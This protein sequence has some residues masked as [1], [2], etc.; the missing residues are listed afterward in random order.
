MP[1]H[2]TRLSFVAVRNLV[3]DGDAHDWYPD[4]ISSLFQTSYDILL[5][6]MYHASLLGIA[7]KFGPLK[8]AREGCHK[9]VCG[10]QAQKQLGIRNIF[11]TRRTQN[12]YYCINQ[13]L[14]RLKSKSL[15]DIR[16]DVTSGVFVSCDI[17][18]Y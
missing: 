12:K 13:P 4:V 3:L 10:T 11:A 1:T 16:K 18:P 14:S 9:G 5:I 7:P 8:C 2:A 6:I 15:T 17:S